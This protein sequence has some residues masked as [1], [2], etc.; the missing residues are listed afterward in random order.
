MATVTKRASWSEMER[1]LLN[2]GYTPYWLCED[3]D[4]VTALTCC[5]CRDRVR[6]VGMHNGHIC[7]AYG[8]C[9]ECD[10][11]LCFEGLPNLPLGAVTDDA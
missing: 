6:Y 10:T 7:W 11:W 2:A 9:A 4:D 1:E 8:I 5:N 3:E